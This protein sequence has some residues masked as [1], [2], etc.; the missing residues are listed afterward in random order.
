MYNK[1]FPNIYV[2]GP[3][4][5]EKANES[6]SDYTVN[7]FPLHKG[8]FAY[9]C[10]SEAAARYKNYSG[11]LLVMDDV[12]LNFWT[13]KDLDFTRL[14]E[15][16]KQP[17]EVSGFSPPAIWYW[18]RSRWGKENCQKAFNE[19]NQFYKDSP[20]TAILA[21]EMLSK[22][23]HNGKGVN[24]CFRGRSDIFYV[25]RKYITRYSLLSSIFRKHNVFLEIAVPT[26]FRLLDKVENFEQLQGYYLPGRVGQEPVMDSRHFWTL[27]SEDLNFVHPLKLHYGVNSTMSLAIVENWFLAKVN[28]LTNCG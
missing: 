3:N 22:L 28:R 9:E 14:W 20:E 21:K 15:G 26:I 10:L 25:P 27:Y 6:V 12:L 24:R 7:R 13:L 23:R 8:Y 16:P 19:V 2:C 18:W 5:A 17:I 11:Y 1:A 4:D